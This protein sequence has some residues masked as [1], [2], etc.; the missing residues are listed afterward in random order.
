MSS[1]SSMGN[2]G[3]MMNQPMMAPSSSFNNFPSTNT[4]NMTASKP[5]YSMNTMQ[6]PLMSSNGGSG[7]ASGAGGWKLPNPMTAQG[8]PNIMTPTTQNSTGS[9]AT[10]AKRLTA[11]DIDSLLG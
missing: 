5:H 7:A 3:N 4:S 6:Q 9:K 11:A 8:H 10:N 2:F 1:S